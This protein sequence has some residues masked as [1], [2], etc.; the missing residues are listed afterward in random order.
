MERMRSNHPCWCGSGAKFKRCHGNRRLLQRERVA[1]GS[2]SPPRPVPDHIVRPD[3]VVAG[4]VGTPRTFQIHD[5]ESLARLRRAGAVAAE[6]LLAAGDAVAPGVTTDEIDAVAHDAYIERGAYPSDLHYKGFT[7]SICTSVNGVICHGVPDDRPL[8][9]GDIVNID[10]TAFIDGMNG[11]TSATFVVG[12]IDAPTLALVGTTRE[13]TLRGIAAVAPGEP[14]RRIG[15]AIE[16][17][18]RSRGFAVVREYGGHGIGETFHA[19]PHIHHHIERRDH[20]PFQVGMS[21]TVEPMLLSG[22]TTF[23]QADDGWTE[24]IDDAMPSAQFEHTIVVTPSGAEIM[25]LTADGHSA[26][27]SLDAAPM[28][29]GAALHR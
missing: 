20:E 4:V 19:A 6:V 22:G 27:G 15:E 11:D 14:L 10:V 18:A 5:N 13:A 23:T 8:Q 28:S 3:Y 16:P 21:F 24:H 9:E 29:A 12:E 1:I 25:T 7:K 26:V 2:V 17:F